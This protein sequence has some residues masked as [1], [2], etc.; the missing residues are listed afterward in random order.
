MNIEF[1]D[2]ILVVHLVGEVD[3]HVADEIKGEISKKINRNIINHL[4]FDFK[5][6][7]FMDS[8]GVGLIIGRYKEMGESNVYCTSLSDNVKK[9]FQ[10]SG[11][12][13]IIPIYNSLESCIKE[14]E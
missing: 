7:N 9:I 8:S 3:H 5:D 4:V 12:L 2:N 13:N 14:I 10:L 6:V 11:L 1:K